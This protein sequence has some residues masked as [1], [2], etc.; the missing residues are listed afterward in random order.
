MNNKSLKKLIIWNIIISISAMVFTL[1][2]KNATS[3]TFCIPETSAEITGIG[4]VRRT[5][6]YHTPYPSWS[7]GCKVLWGDGSCIP[8]GHNNQNIW[9]QCI[10]GDIGNRRRFG[11][12]A[13]INNRLSDT[14]SGY[15]AYQ[16]SDDPRMFFHYWVYL[17]FKNTHDVEWWTGDDVF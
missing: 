8:E 14:A 7:G 13:E 11:A 10:D 6:H 3:T 16:K 15:N 9:F 5:V 12:F 17:C 1:S 2:T 4:R